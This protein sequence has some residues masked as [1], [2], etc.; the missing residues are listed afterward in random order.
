MIKSLPEALVP[1]LK[2][3]VIIP[4]TYDGPNG[5]IPDG[6]RND[7]LNREAGRL[8]HYGWD[9]P[10]IYEA[11]TALNNNRCDPPLLEAEV[12][13]I[14][15]GITRYEPTRT[16]FSEAPLDDLH[17]TEWGNA[18]RLVAEYGAGMLY[19]KPQKVWYCW[20]GTHWEEDKTGEIQRLTKNTVQAI[21]GEASEIDDKD[22]RKKRVKW[23]LSSESDSRMKA[24]ISLAQSEP[25]IQIMP[26]LFDGDPWLLNTGSGVIDLKTGELQRRQRQ[27]YM[28]KLVPTY[29]DQ[30]EECP[31]WEQF[32]WDIT[33]GDEQLIAFLKRAIGYSL[34]GITSEQVIFVLYG[35]GSNGKSTF[36]NTVRKMLGEYACHTPTETLLMKRNDGIPNDL[37]R[38]R[39][40][41][42]V[43]AL[44]AE[45]G[46]RLAESLVKQMTGDDPIT[47]RYLYQELF[48]FEP[49]F[50]VWLGTNHKPSIRGTD[51]A[52][53]RRI[54]L[55]PF[56][57]T[58]QD[59]DQDKDLA[60]KM[61]KE[62]PGILAWAVEGCLE[63]QRVGLSAPST[64]LE[65][66]SKYRKEMDEIATF[67]DET[68]VADP[69]EEVQASVLY[70]AYNTWAD[71]NGYKPVNS[72][73]FGRS[74]VERGYV[75]RKAARV[76]Y[77]GLKLQETL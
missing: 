38:L 62:W 18:Q 77:S 49:Q 61:K 4:Q 13:A 50:K 21:Y 35:T 33:D 25:G 3:P 22:E 7:T 14:A 24:T 34:T 72:T 29:Y 54:R 74:L 30:S 64:V 48:E 10:E 23:A 6:K 68:C 44:E 41:R 59:V 2:K 28:T 46:R 16:L 52:I 1:L 9:E 31:L 39:G 58:I 70:K 15:H 56:T 43:T 8:R 75:K 36:I 32:L 19:C 12:L 5:M 69:E 76:Y 37:A 57:V 66:T 60:E 11:I 53:W 40:A 45:E 27:D 73:V 26:D 17:L 51:H 42:L 20:R 67:I 71:V 47:A 65:A 63:W 55:I